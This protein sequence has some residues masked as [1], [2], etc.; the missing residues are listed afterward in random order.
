MERTARSNPR[1]ETLAILLEVFR[2][3]PQF[4]Q[5]NSG[6]VSG[7]FYDRFLPNPSQFIIH[8]STCNVTLR[9]VDGDILSK[10][11]CT[12]IKYKTQ[13]SFKNTGSLLKSALYPFLPSGKTK[14]I[15]HRQQSVKLELRMF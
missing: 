3:F 1:T 2:D 9:C 7:L 12:V 6:T 4:I 10:A 8:K 11:K 5:A 14:F 15:T 13:T